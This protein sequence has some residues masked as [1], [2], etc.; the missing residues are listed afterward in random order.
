M[1]N[2]RESVIQYIKDFGG[3][4]S[5]EA[6]IDLGITQLA[7]RISELK[8]LGNNFKTEWVY[9]KNRYGKLVKFK[10]YMLEEVI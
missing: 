3:I 10:R 2:Q 5:Y 6:Y 4:T 8:E 1:I 9:K 7:T